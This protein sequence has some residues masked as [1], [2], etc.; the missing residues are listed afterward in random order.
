MADEHRWEDRFRSW[1]HPDSFAHPDSP[2]GGSGTGFS[3]PAGPQRYSWPSSTHVPHPDSPAGRHF[4]WQTELPRLAIEERARAVYQALA[5]APQYVPGALYDA[6]GQ[7]LNSIVSGIIPGLIMFVGVLAGTTALGAGTGA[8]I[9][10]LAFGVGAAAGAAAG[11]GLGFDAGI[12]LLEYLGLAFLV[13]Y[14]GKSLLQG[15]TVAGEAVQMA[16]HSVDNRSTQRMAVDRAARK[17]AFAVG[18][19]FRGVLQGMV[20]F[21]LAKGTSAAASRVPELVSKL[22]ASKLGAGFAQW[23]EKNWKGLIDN[24]RLT[25]AQESGVRRSG[26]GFAEEEVPASPTKPSQQIESISRSRT[27]EAEITPPPKPPATFVG[28]LGSKQVEMKGVSTKRIEYR[29]RPRPEYADLRKQFDGGKRQEFLKRLASDP[30]Q[31]KLLKDA[32]ISETGLQKMR[33]GRVPDGWQVHHK[34]P[35]DDGGT[36]DPSNLVLIKN[37]PAHQVLTNAQSSLV[38]DLTEGQIRTVD[39]PVPDGKVY[40][41][42]PSM[43]RVTP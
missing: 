35:L 13:G 36:N 6:T 33:D 10:A 30:Q 28:K 22:R 26:G 31:I 18:L 3:R 23:I 15:A 5:S 14:V 24:P 41:P 39:F 16:W 40:P 4:S 29:K 9:G 8:A 34:L 17:L 37:N 27:E 1:S 20:A 32:G 19:V 12:A 25:G 42:D 21:L 11:A 43:V 2:A 7:E 38:G